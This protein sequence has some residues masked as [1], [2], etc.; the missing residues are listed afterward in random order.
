MSKK[1]IDKYIIK[2]ETDGVKQSEKGLGQLE[3]KSKSLIST[4]TKLKA[5]LAVVG[6]ALIAIGKYSLDSASNFEQLRTRLNAMYGSVAQGTQAFQAFVNI[7]STTPFA[8]S[9]VVEAGAQL[10]AFGLD[11]EESIKPVAD[12]AAF[13]GVDVVEAANAMGRAFAGGAGAADVLRERGI[14][15]L[16]RDFKGIEDLTKLTL[17]EFRSVLLETIQDPTAGIAG[18]TDALSKTFAGAYSNMMD[19]V[20]QLGASIGEQLLPSAT[21]AVRAITS[22]INAVRGAEEPH[23]AQITQLRIQQQTIRTLAGSITNLNLPQDVRI[24]KIRELQKEYPDFL[25]NMKAEDVTNQNITDSL[26]DLNKQTQNKIDQIIQEEALS[27]QY[28]KQKGLIDDLTNQYRLINKR[29][30]D[31]GK[32]M[33]MLNDRTKDLNDRSVRGSIFQTTLSEKLRLSGETSQFM[34]ETVALL[35]KDVSDLYTEYQKGGMTQDAYN[36]GLKELL[37]NSNLNVVAH[38]EHMTFLGKLIQSEEDLVETNNKLNDTYEETQNEIDATKGVIKKL[39]DELDNTDPDKPIVKPVDPKVIKS[40]EKLGKVITNEILKYQTD[41][42][43]LTEDYKQKELRILQNKD[44]QTI[45]DISK[46][47]DIKLNLLDDEHR[48]ELSALTER[49]NEL[50]ADKQKELDLGIET[51]QLS[52]EQQQDFIQE[53]KDLEATFANDRLTLISGYELDKKIIITDGLDAEADR[54]DEHHQEMLDKEEQYQDSL[55]AIKQSTLELQRSLFDSEK[56]LSRSH[57]ESIYQDALNSE[58][59]TFVTTERI[60]KFRKETEDERFKLTNDTNQKILDDLKASHEAEYNLAL[61][62]YDRDVELFKQQIDEDGERTTFEKQMLQ[63]VQDDADAL[64]LSAKTK[65][66]KQLL[67]ADKAYQEADKA[68][69]KLHNKEVNDIDFMSAKARFDIA[70]GVGANLVN[71]F[72]QNAGKLFNMNK[73]DKKNLLQL[74]KGA[75]IA[76]G[77]KEIV[78]IWASEPRGAKGWPIKT[79]LSLAA[80]LRTAGNVAG[81]DQQ[82]SALDSVS[83]S[84]NAGGGSSNTFSL[85]QESAAIGYSGVIDSPTNM[86]VGEAGAEMVNVTP[87]DNRTESNTAT[88][89]N[90]SGNVMSADFVE[91]DLPELIK[92]AIRKGA[93]FGV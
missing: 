57:A 15:T 43:K 40:Y 63:Q 30:N 61:E 91:N 56:E 41:S 60:A 58:I 76:L 67:D 38:Q 12:L 90:I 81:I 83:S 92:E 93:D 78:D 42:L 77:I 88:A 29:T 11:A 26:K 82:I 33:K 7:A 27:K 80:G 18:A 68:N 62:N 6:T 59:Q 74:E 37:Q 19:S 20:E 65:F 14:L 21:S 73:K 85:N 13:M 86:L 45:A 49:Q 47:T 3:N 32:T 2:V 87:L 10:K 71:A 23:K 53:M 70:V 69:K 24:Q 28:E 51:K 52:K 75:A 50:L 66:D 31:F 34:G 54:L 79:A 4:S 5:G 17:P 1:T 44:N 55:R 25:K 84:V 64:K 89:V 48:R 16:I 36:E 22:M 35:V 72:S 9:S 8:V 39:N 46:I